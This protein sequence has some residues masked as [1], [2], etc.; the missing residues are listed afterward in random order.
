M[1]SSKLQFNSKLFNLGENL[2]ADNSNY[3][4]GYVYLLQTWTKL[5]NFFTKSFER[6][7]L[8][9]V[10]FTVFASSEGVSISTS[11]LEM[12]SVCMECKVRYPRYYK[13]MLLYLKKPLWRKNLQ[14]FY[15]Y[16]KSYFSTDD[17]CNVYLQCKETWF[18]YLFC[19]LKVFQMV[20]R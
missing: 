5:F 7:Y 15:F 9:E 18:L 14:F 2:R 1:V 10:I 3:I 13:S 12:L 16:F 8:K 20:S 6:S 11:E 17:F 4:I 19:L